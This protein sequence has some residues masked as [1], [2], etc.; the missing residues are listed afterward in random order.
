MLPTT[1]THQAV[2][3]PRDHQPDEERFRVI[4]SEDVLWRV[5]PRFRRPRGDYDKAGAETGVIAG[6]P[7]VE[8]SRAACH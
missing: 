5:F 7:S 4:H 2:A 8:M 1:E 6:H 3:Q